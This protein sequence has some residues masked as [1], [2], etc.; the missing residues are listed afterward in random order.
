MH[1]NI[2]NEEAKLLLFID[3]MNYISRLCQKMLDTQKPKPNSQV[4]AISDDINIKKYQ[5][6]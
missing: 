4:E 3:L 1:Q 2:Q 6:L 5:V